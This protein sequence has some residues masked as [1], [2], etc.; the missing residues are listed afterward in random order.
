LRV[1]AFLLAILLL[2]DAMM[3]TTPILLAFTTE[4]RLPEDLL[5][6]FY[7]ALI[8]SLYTS[9]ISSSL[10]LLVAIPASFYISRRVSRRGPLLAVIMLPMAISPAAV[11][12]LLLLFFT[13]TPLGSLVNEQLGI[14]NDV[15]GIIVAQFFLELPLGISYFTAIFATIPRSY[16]EV[17]LVMGFS[18]VEYLYRILVP[19]VRRQL[20]IGLLLVFT[21]A[22]GDFGASYVVGGGIRGKTV[23][24]PIYLFIVNQIGEVG[25]L[26]IALAMYVV[27]I[28]IIL[29]LIY[30]VEGSGRELM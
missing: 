8:L 12:L 25:V 10:I 1:L 29:T 23:T 4:L 13:K 2:L 30:H 17:A 14:V 18:Y 16:D 6:E 27:S 7:Q 3:I 9:A 28:L 22:L 21:R 20:F 11:G 15:K 26:T 19:M 24:L 5:K